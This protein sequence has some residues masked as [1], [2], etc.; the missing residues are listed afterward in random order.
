MCARGN[1]APLISTMC[2]RQRRSVVSDSSRRRWLVIANT[3][4]RQGHISFGVRAC[5]QSLAC[6]ASP[7]PVSAPIQHAQSFS[8]R[9]EADRRTYE[10]LRHP[11]RLCR[12]YA[13]EDGRRSREAAAA[14]ARKRKYAE[15]RARLE[16]ARRCFDWAGSAEEELRELHSVGS[17]LQACCTRTFPL[18][19]DC[20]SCSG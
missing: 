19:Y 11:R 6:K 17:E 13:L 18:V 10:R 8:E 20:L 5:S 1:D 7:T 2:A 16:D 9:R 4:Q 3:E 14:L 12:E 15:A